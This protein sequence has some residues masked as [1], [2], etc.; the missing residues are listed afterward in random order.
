MNKN[1]P[2]AKF[3]NLDLE[4]RGLQDRLQFLEAIKDKCIALHD[5]EE[6]IC[7]ELVSSWGR[8]GESSERQNAESAT[9]EFLDVVE[10]LPVAL[11]AKYDAAVRRTFSYGY[12]SVDGNSSASVRL[13]DHTVD[14][15]RAAKLEIE[16]VIYPIV[17]N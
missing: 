8:V 6:L 2:S 14:R 5:S 15:I 1:E 11:R 16:V 7:L 9:S 4:L 3:I 10:N 13:P 17:R 12:Q